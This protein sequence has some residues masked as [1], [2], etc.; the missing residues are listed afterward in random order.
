MIRTCCCCPC[1]AMQVLLNISL[2]LVAEI[3]LSISLCLTTQLL[4]NISPCLAT[5]DCQLPVQG[6]PGTSLITVLLLTIRA[7][8]HELRQPAQHCAVLA[9]TMFRR[10]LS[11]QGCPAFETGVW[12][13]AG[14][15]HGVQCCQPVV[16]G[17]VRG[18]RQVSFSF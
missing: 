5:L 6:C 17:G 10:Q 18:R 15:C 1:L 7:A 12:L 3:L 11:M 16:E 2:C 8:D 14:H 4:L 13:A 9:V